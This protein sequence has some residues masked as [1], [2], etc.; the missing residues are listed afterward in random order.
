MHRAASLLVISAAAPPNHRDW[1][2]DA[3]LF[4]RPASLTY[5]VPSQREAAASGHTPRGEFLR[6]WR[7]TTSPS[8]S[9]SSAWHAAHLRSLL[10]RRAAAGRP[11]INRLALRCRA[12]VCRSTVVAGAQEPPTLVTQ[13]RHHRADGRRPHSLCPQRLLL[14]PPAGRNSRAR[15]RPAP[16]HTTAA[17]RSAAKP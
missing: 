17:H 11:N 6:S 1:T 7:A 13:A 4:R 3:L 15:P 2:R 5:A 9:P 12:L 14:R 8:I 10:P 16:V